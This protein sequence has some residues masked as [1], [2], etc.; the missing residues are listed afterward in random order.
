LRHRRTD[1]R[2]QCRERALHFLRWP[3]TRHC[4]RI[5][6]MSALVRPLGR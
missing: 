1:S 6:A 2:D 3:I 5:R 4:F